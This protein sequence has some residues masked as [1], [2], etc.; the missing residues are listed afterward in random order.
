ML[1][2]RKNPA[3]TIAAPQVFDYVVQAIDAETIQGQMA[4]R[5]VNA[6][7]SLLEMTG[8]NVQQIATQMPAAR[9]PVI[10]RYFL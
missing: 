9:L 6:T 4:D 8:L 10:Q 2:I 3:V 7:K 1:P 5:V